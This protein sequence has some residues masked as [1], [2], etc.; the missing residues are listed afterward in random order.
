MP[1][2]AYNAPERNIARGRRGLWC[3]RGGGG[4]GGGRIVGLHARADELMR[5]RDG[6]SKDFR[7]A[8]SEQG[9]GVRELVIRAPV[10]RPPLTKPDLQLLIRNEI[11]RTM[12]NTHQRW[13]EPMEIP[14]HPL[15]SL[16]R[17]QTLPHTRI[18]ALGCRARAQHPRLH[19]PDRIRE[20]G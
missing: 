6:A 1:Y 7:Q 8:G 9:I 12:T 14:P 17:F 18:C 16:Y 19:D 3:N 20:H 13:R 4:D 15:G 11:Q 10:S 2:A 5:V